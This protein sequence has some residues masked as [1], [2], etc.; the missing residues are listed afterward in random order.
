MTRHLSRLVRCAIGLP[1]C[2]SF[3]KNR[4]FLG[5]FFILI[6]GEEDD[7]TLHINQQPE[8]TQPQNK[9]EICWRIANMRRLMNIALSI[10]LMLT[11]VSPVIVRAEYVKS[12]QDL[13]T[14]VDNDR[15]SLVRKASLQH[16]NQIRNELGVP[17][18]SFDDSLQQAAQAH[19][20]YENSIDKQKDVIDKSFHWEETTTNPWYTGFSADDRANFFG[21]PQGREVEVGEV[22]HSGVI[23]DEPFGALQSLI[24]APFHRTSLLDPSY[25][26]FGLGA[27][28]FTTVINMGHKT[29][30][31]QPIENQQIVYYP[32]DGQ[33]NSPTSWWNIETPNPLAYYD[34]IGTQVGYPITISGDQGNIAYFESLSASIVDSNG[35]AV[36]YYVVDHNHF[37]GE[38][39][40]G[41]GNTVILIPKKPLRGATTYTITAAFRNPN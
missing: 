25:H 20:Q 5:G 40:Y 24:D 11:V 2:G 13:Y 12:G 33:T 31:V 1:N 35:Q 10:A 27:T 32:Y 15:L 38:S 3:R 34:I 4:L 23:F 14:G 41:G 29:K 6:S 7:C 9:K 28:D 30:A 37:I 16:I 26:D 8:P 36:D 18:W 21:Y 17:L 22:A 19:S 39:G